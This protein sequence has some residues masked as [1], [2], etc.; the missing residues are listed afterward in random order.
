MPTIYQDNNGKTDNSDVRNTFKNMSFEWV[1]DINLLSVLNTRTIDSTEIDSVPSK[2]KFG[3]LVITGYERNKRIFVDN[4][5]STGINNNFYDTVYFDDVTFDSLNYRKFYNSLRLY[6]SPYK[7]LSAYFGMTNEWNRYSFHVRDYSVDSKE[8][9]NKYPVNN[10]QYIPFTYIHP[11]SNTVLNSGLKLSFY[12]LH[13]D[14]SAN[15]TLAGYNQ[16]DVDLNGKLNFI[17]TS[18]KIIASAALTLAS[19]KPS[20]LFENYYSNN[21]IWKNN[22]SPTTRMHLSINFTHSPK[23]FETEGNYALLRGVVYF[24]TNAFPKQYNEEL[25]VFS[26]S[27]KKDFKFWKINSLNKITLQYVSNSTV[28]DLPTLFFRIQLFFNNVC[29]SNL[30]VESFLQI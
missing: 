22:F 2:M 10:N 17:P 29:I 13:W 30:L 25:Q 7:G 11:F 9:I 18:E 27:V 24:D 4:N 12:N 8:E 6:F 5:P 3:L 26:G 19:E 28:I 20:Y 23:K 14:I 1:N 15:Y 16:N 21:F